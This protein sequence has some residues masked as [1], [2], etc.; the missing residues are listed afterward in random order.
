MEKGCISR[1]HKRS[2]DVTD[3]DD[4]IGIIP[5]ED[6]KCDV[7]V[8]RMKYEDV[9][10]YAPLIG[11]PEPYYLPVDFEAGLKK[12]MADE[13]D[14]LRKIGMEEYEESLNTLL[15]SLFDSHDV[16]YA[17]IITENVE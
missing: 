12:I 15:K 3:F 11:F 4:V 14:K 8:K 10:K 5:K 7:K 1:T 6:H 2:K 16:S 17:S 9:N 13:F